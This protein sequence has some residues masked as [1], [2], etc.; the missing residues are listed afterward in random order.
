M[1]LANHWDKILKH[2]RNCS[3]KTKITWYF[4]S[5]LIATVIC[6]LI[7]VTTVFTERFM[8][9]K[10]DLLLG[11]MTVLTK[12]IE[13]K[14]DYIRNFASS[15]K[16]DNTVINA[17]SLDDDYSTINERL[18][19]FSSGMNGVR[20]IFIVDNNNYVLNNF[21]KQYSDFI[22]DEI[23]RPFRSKYKEN[24]LSP[25]NN[26]PSGINA[27]YMKND[28]I[29]YT[30]QIRKKNTSEDIGYLVMSVSRNFLFS[31]IKSYAKAE[32][33]YTYIVS[34]EGKVIYRLGDSNDDLEHNI[35]QLSSYTYLHH[36]KTTIDGN[37]YFKVPLTN[38]PDWNVISIVSNQS[39][40]KDLYYIL[41][42]IVFVGFVTVTLSIFMGIRLSKKITEPILT[43]S[44]A[45]QSFQK[46]EIIPKVEANTEDEVGYL[47]KGFNSM[48]DEIAAF[49]QE[50]YDR[51]EEKK[52]AEV[53]AQKFHI[54][55]LQSQI[56]PH[57]LYN[58]LNTVSFLAMKNQTSE[59]RDLIQS[60]SL[61]L[62]STITN[63]NEFIT[64]KNE[65]EF[66]KAY[67]KIQNYRYGNI[68]DLS[69][70]LEDEA[71]EYLIPKLI[72]QP[73]VENALLHGI[74]QREECLGH[75]LV[76]INCYSSG[77]DIAI[78]DDGVGMNMKAV[79]LSNSNKG[80]KSSGFNS[81][82]I[83]NVTNRLQLYYGEMSKLAVESILG[84]GTIV[85]FQIPKHL[86]EEELFEEQ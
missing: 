30:Q 33:D 44:S 32:Y 80:I 42:T 40:K 76:S 75:I 43:L 19:Q 56:N 62:R 52:K 54:E 82:G 77:I 69:F 47:I 16:N 28:Y 50:I 17:M 53:A 57:F 18:L 5:F 51:Q 63:V 2:F 78:V 21:Y 35:V 3:I 6:I 31:G 1:W 65:I 15:V 37:T 48:M 61:L 4:A 36:T 71:L 60:L 13:Q 81:M 58:T 67:V 83:S 45:M 86:L 11:K 7:L 24:I 20:S 14:I 22:I 85:T 66:L 68:I 8:I 25:P 74:F 79:K 10:N 41:L 29:T 55:L 59:I 12:D 26:F 46:G 23:I 73:I 72:L 38:Y 34:K 9:Q 84:V 27:D 39:L 70:C 64:I 49:I